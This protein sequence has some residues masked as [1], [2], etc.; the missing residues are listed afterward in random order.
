MTPRSLIIQGA[1]AVLVLALGTS[2]ALASDPQNCLLCHKFKRLRAYDQSGVLHNYYVDMH[3]FN[4]SI[5]RDVTCV[6]CHSDVS[7]IPHGTIAKVDCA[8]MCHIDGWEERT[9]R[10]FSH[11][12][13]AR[14]LAAS[15]HGLRPE[16]PPEVAALKPDC[17]YCHLN[18]LYALPE[19]V[20]S[21]TVLERCMN[22]H[23][24]QGLTKTFTHIS[25]RFKHKT[26]RPPL[27]I[28]D[29]CASCHADPDFINVVGFTGPQANAVS[30][31]K[32]TIHYRI[33]Q[34]GGTDT[35][36]CVSCHAS[37]SIHDIR[38]PGDP[39][40][41]IHPSNRYQ[42][43]RTQ[44]CHPGASPMISSVDSHLSKHSERG[45]EI[46]IV[47][48][49]M[50]AVMFLTL[51]VLFSLMGLET[52]ARLRNRDARFFR[53][54]RR[55]A[56][57]LRETRSAAS[58]L[59][60]VPNLHRYVAS[61]PRGDLP[62]YSGHIMFTHTLMAISF[63]VAVATG[64]P[65]FFHN[66]ELSHTVIRLMGGIEV[67]RMIHRVNAV[68]FTL[69]CAYHVLVLMLGTIVKLQRGT[70]DIRRTQIPLL[71][72][73][74]DL[75]ADV[76][77]FLGLEP[78]RPRMEKFM[79]KQKLHYLAMVWGCAVLTLSGCCLLFPEAMVAYIP[80]PKVS[81]NVLR[82]MHAEE[83]VLAFLVI[84]LWHLYNVHVAP[85]RFPMQWTFWNGRIARDHQIEEHYL[86][87]ARQVREGVAECEEDRLTG[88]GE[89]R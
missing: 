18:D 62:R 21:D 79:Y 76:R 61:D 12:S 26:S 64:L 7:K 41:S 1:I 35:A 69:D 13:V 8:K 86:E 9:G 16:D 15:V 80:F 37:Q 32:E 48:L 85:G 66:A 68:V 5:H 17:R 20:P 50:E 67:T 43:C 44:E 34:F 40:S 46:H 36:Q 30:T 27:E 4:R 3:L 77:Y 71:K 39:L 74:R 55:P 24:E 23:T 89:K 73:L 28:V 88:K 45:P 63:T 38:P 84:T 54:R 59:G 72:D 78:Q 51:F 33:L 42:T 19:E 29:L 2:A 81:F 82:L 11:N 53:W 83:S 87:Y 70:F 60:S 58:G 56:P 57:L 25:H 52:C 49:I 6:G 75:Y 65:L 31:Y 10:K 47:E 22:C 14:T